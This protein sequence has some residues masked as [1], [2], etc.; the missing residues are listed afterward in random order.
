ME[1]RDR[2]GVATMLSHR[3]GHELHRDR[4]CQ[5]DRAIPV[6]PLADKSRAIV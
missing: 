6:V 4:K 2:D 3:T 1:Q 5:V